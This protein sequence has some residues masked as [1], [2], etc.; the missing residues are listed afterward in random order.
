MTSTAAIAAPFDRW[1]NDLGDILALAEQA[2]VQGQYPLAI[3]RV[4]IFP[5]LWL[6]QY[7]VLR[8]NG[9]AI[10]FVNWA[11][12][13]DAM[14]AAYEECPCQLEPEDWQG[15]RWLWFMEI[16]GDSRHMPD[17]VDQL[18]RVIPRNSVAR[19]HEVDAVGAGSLR[20]RTVRF[21][22]DRGEASGRPSA[23]G[24]E[25]SFTQHKSKD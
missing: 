22:P 12:L 11:W 7:L 25:H 15:G 4:R 8:Q 18:R 23:A 21:G 10:M 19:W 6:G 9:K 3:L 13:D 14:S 1:M 16:L 24:A 5:S 17:L 20:L 2:V